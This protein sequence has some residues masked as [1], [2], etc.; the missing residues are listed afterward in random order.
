MRIKEK[1]NSDVGILAVHLIK[2][3]NFSFVSSK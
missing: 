2:R 1:N 3:Y